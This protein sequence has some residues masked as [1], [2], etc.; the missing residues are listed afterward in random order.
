LQE[1][2]DK[3]TNGAVYV[4]FGSNVKSSSLGPELVNIIVQT[5]SNLPYT[6]LWKW[7]TDEI[8]KF[9]GSNV[10]TRKWFQQ[11]DILSK[12]PVF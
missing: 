9:Q 12:L 8:P 5:V 3:A 11:Q 2:L 10:I 4:S 7:E 1:V 6:V